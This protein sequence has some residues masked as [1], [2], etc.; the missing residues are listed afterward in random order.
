MLVA[1]A[2]SVNHLSSK[3]KNPIQTGQGS[4]VSSARTF[5]KH[6]REMRCLEVLRSFQPDLGLW[7]FQAQGRTSE[8][9]LLTGASSRKPLTH[10]AESPRTCMCQAFTSLCG[11]NVAFMGLCKRFASVR[12]KSIMACVALLP[13]SSLSIQL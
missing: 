13:G 9:N 6:P 4:S 5:G 3:P 10:H 8:K 2:T 11:A 7:R 12:T 1:G